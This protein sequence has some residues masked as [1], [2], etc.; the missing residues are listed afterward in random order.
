[1]PFSSQLSL[2]RY[3]PLGDWLSTQPG[4][5]VTLTFAEVQ[6]ILGQPLPATARTSNAWWLHAERYRTAAARVWHAAGWRLLEVNRQR[7]TVTYVRNPA[8]AFHL[9]AASDAREE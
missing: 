7:A 2:A 5:Q 4:E 6:Q 1:M 3:Q 8:A 9:F